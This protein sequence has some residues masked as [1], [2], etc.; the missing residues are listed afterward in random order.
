MTRRSF[1]DAVADSDLLH[2]LVDSVSDRFQAA[3]DETRPDR[4]SRPEPDV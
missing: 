1:P 4:T 3:W 2:A